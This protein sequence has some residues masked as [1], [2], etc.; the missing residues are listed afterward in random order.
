MRGDGIMNSP[1]Q[2]PEH[3]KVH[4]GESCEGADERVL[5]YRDMAHTSKKGTANLPIITNEH[6]GKQSDTVGR[7]DL[8]PGEALVSLAGVYG[9]GAKKYTENNW[10]KITEQDHINHALEHLAFY[11]MGDSSEPHLDH[12]LCR[13]SMAVWARDNPINKVFLSGSTPNVVDSGPIEFRTVEG[14]VVPK[15]YEGL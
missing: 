14:Q 13:L 2:V 4:I 10:H 11:Q 8:I 3:P 1:T 9:A 5:S 7:F 6:G 15:I 12:A